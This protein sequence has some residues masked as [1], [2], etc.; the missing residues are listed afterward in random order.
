MIFTSYLERSEMNKNV[1]IIIE[2]NIGRW[3]RGKR[4]DAVVAYHYKDSKENYL[5]RYF[6]DC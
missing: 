1:E 6:Y 4:P 3:R 2:P 5:L